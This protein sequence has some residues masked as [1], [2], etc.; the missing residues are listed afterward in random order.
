MGIFGDGTQSR[1]YL[2]V[3]DIVQAYNMVLNCT[4]LVGETINVGSG[5]IASV[6]EIAEFVATEFGASIEYRPGRSG[7]VKGFHLDSSKARGLG[8]EPKVPFWE[9][10]TRYIR[11]RQ[12]PTTAQ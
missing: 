5:S 12:Q 11:W 3:D 6:G 2:N 1:E 10:L 7:E 8:F 9:G 4:D